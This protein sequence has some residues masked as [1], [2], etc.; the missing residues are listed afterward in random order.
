[1]FT[2]LYLSG[3][4][5]EFKQKIGSSVLFWPTLSEKLLPKLQLAYRCC[6]ATETGVLK[7]VSNILLAADRGDVTL[8][9]L[10]EISAALDTVNPAILLDRLQTAFGIKGT[11]LS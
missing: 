6:H 10:L 11:A 4:S 9:G 5:L 8:L 7:M 3:E 1:M 2:Q